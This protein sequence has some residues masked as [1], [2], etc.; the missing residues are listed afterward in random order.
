MKLKCIG[1]E[2]DGTS[3][4][5]EHVKNGDLVR[6]RKPSKFE[7]PLDIDLD[8][9]LLV[10]EEVYYEIF[11]LSFSDRNNDVEKHYFLKPQGWSTAKAVIYQ[12]GK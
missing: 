7:I 11:V 2:L 5:I 6:L 8:P 9:K 1:G 12:F 3:H 10:I 4:I